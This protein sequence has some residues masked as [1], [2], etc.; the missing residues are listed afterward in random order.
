MSGRRCADQGAQKICCDRAIAVALAE[1]FAGWLQ[2]V[3][4]T[5]PSN[6]A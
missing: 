5:L 6:L 4:Q 3:P 1:R 2:S